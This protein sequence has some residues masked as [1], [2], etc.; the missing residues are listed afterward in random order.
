MSQVY[1]NR[2]CPLC[3]KTAAASEDYAENTIVDTRT[4]EQSF[5]CGDSQCGY[6]ASSEIKQ[7]DG[8]LFWVETVHYPIDNT[9]KVLCPAA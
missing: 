4:R 6:S 5:L 1:A 2:Q 8:R 7:I 9:G 3:G